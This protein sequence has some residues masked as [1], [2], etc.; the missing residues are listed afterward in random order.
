MAG[1]E[2]I[3][4]DE[5]AAAH[6]LRLLDGAL[7]PLHGHNWEVEVELAGPR[8]DGMEVLI[9]FTQVRAQLRAAAARLHDTFLNDL[10]E[11]VGRN[12]SAEQVAVYF[13]DA[14]RPNLPPTVHLTRV[15]VW[16]TRGCAAAWSAAPSA[17]IAARDS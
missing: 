13:R 8:L 3:V 16:E 12:P 17:T 4:R 2:V 15:R 10:P 5:F 1:F 9:D 11:F 6:Q 14:L 7:E